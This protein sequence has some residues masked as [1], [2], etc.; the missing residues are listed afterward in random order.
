MS[1][2][3]P[4][5]RATASSS[6][7]GFLARLR[8]WAIGAKPMVAA[9]DRSANGP[10]PAIRLQLLVDPTRRVQVVLKDDDRHTPVDGPPRRIR[11]LEVT[12]TFT[13]HAAAPIQLQVEET[14][15]PVTAV[16][17]ASVMGLKGEFRIT[18]RVRIGTQSCRLT[19]RK[20]YDPEREVQPAL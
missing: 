15:P 14:V 6:A 3:I 7:R 17:F 20:N 4:A 12:G 11:W 1:L 9:G 5:S 18:A 8:Q 10:I 2:A 13:P 19:F 16:R